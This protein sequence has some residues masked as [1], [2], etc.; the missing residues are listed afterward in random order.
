MG[1]WSLFIVHVVRRFA[2]AFLGWIYDMEFH[3]VENIP[4]E[5]PIILTPNHV[6]YLDPIFM[7][8]AVKRRLFFMTWADLFRIPVLSLTMRIFGAFPLK[9]EGHDRRAFKRAH[10]HIRAGE[11]IVIFPEG[12]RTTT[13]KLEY[14]KP[15]AFRLALKMGTPVVPVT[16]NGAY[17]VW[18]PKQT[19]PNLRGKVVIYYHPPILLKSCSEPD[20]KVRAVELAGQVRRAVLTTI[21]PLMA[22]DDLPE[23]LYGGAEARK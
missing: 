16:I 18:P 14:F 20:L 11:G 1:L 4:S 6:S 12:G 19:L 3:G 17:Q 10:K 13:G 23:D 8:L 5:G 22:P 9:L 21:D 15:G 7:G 2:K